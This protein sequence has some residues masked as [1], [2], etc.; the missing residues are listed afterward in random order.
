MIRRPP[1]STRTDTLFPYTTLFRSHPRRFERELEP[2]LA[3]AQC[4]LG[5]GAFGRIGGLDEDARNLAARVADRLIDEIE[6]SLLAAV[7]GEPDGH[8]MAA[9]RLAGHKHAVEQRAERSEERRVGKECVG[10]CRSRWSPD[11]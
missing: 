6:Q 10:T 4:R 2:F 9:I 3:L 11:H 5:A 8:R 7:A 1:R